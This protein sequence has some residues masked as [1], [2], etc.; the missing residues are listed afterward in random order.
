M[1]TIKGWFTMNGM[2]IPIMEGQSKAAAANKYMNSKHGKEV[3]RLSS[4]TYT[5]KKENKFTDSYESAEKAADM[6]EFEKYQSFEKSYQEIVGDFYNKIGYSEKPHKTN[7]AEVE[8]VSKTSEF[9]LLERG[10]RG[11]NKEEIQ[12]YI[13]QFKNGDMYIRSTKSIW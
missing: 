13:N 11:N 5:K 7:A 9:G 4:K 2:H 6:F 8:R 12:E 10:Y 1:A 3:A